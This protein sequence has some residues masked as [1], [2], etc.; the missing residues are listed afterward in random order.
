M[1]RI[2]SVI[3]FVAFVFG[4]STAAFATDTQTL[5]NG[6]T[7]SCPNT[8]II[9]PGSGGTY[10]IHDSGGEQITITIPPSPPRHDQF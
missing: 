4:S 6:W 1:R 3:L 5:P 8:C 7:V 2:V 9:T 10:E